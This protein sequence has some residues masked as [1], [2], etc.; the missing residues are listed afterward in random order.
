MSAC[1]T[2]QV[3]QRVGDLEGEGRKEVER[4][5]RVILITVFPI[6][7]APK[8]VQKGMPTAPQAMP[9]K[10]NNGLGI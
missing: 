3:E 5:C 8:N 7:V 10:S 2:S 4:T 6:S 1:D 9:T